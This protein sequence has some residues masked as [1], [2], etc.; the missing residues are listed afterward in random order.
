M[1]LNLS[2]LDS[3]SL[4]ET[5]FPYVVVPGFLAE[6]ALADI[7][8]DFPKLDLAGL[9]PPEELAFGPAFAELLDLM[10]G[11][12]LRRVVG[13]KFSV[14]LSGRPTMV[15]VR[16]C[17]RA[18]DGRIHRDATFKLVSLILY[19]NR[20][21]YP[22]GGRL[23]LLNAAGDIDNF[24][25]EVPPEGGLLVAF[26]CTENAWHGHKSVVGPRRYVMMNYVQDEEVRR[27]ELARHQFSAKVKKVKR[28]FGLGKVPVPA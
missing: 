21:W 5:P 19:L 26:R 9:F 15:T 10:Q 17:A 2:A 13:R 20:G 1:Q 8:R 6:P 22:D 4:T 28:A 3:A 25:A 16:A 11:E 23:R 27:R 18:R 24:V 14:D 7:S 12:D